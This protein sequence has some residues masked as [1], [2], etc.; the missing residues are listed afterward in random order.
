MLRVSAPWACRILK[1]VVQPGLRHPHPGCCRCAFSQ[2][3]ESTT[4]ALPQRARVVV[5]GGGIAGLSVAYHLSKLGW[6]DIVLLEQGT[7]ASGT[8]WSATGLLGLLRRSHFTTRLSRMSYDLYSQLEDETGIQTGLRRCGSVYIGQT[9]DVMV[10][11]RKKHA[12][13]HA[14]GI[15]SEL[16]SIRDISRVLPWIRVDDAEGGL[17]VKDDARVRSMDV[18]RALAKAIASRGVT[19]LENVVVK[20][21]MTDEGSV[22]SVETDRGTIDCEAFVNCAGLWAYNIGLASSPEVR[23]PVY[24]VAQQYLTTKPIKNLSLDAQ[25]PYIRDTESLLYIQEHNGGFLFGG[26]APKGKPIFDE[27]VPLQKDPGNIQLPDDWDH[28][29]HLLEGFLHRVPLAANVQ[30]EKLSNYPEGF[31]PDGEF[32]MGEAP[33]VRNYYILAGFSSLGLAYAGGAGQL[34]AGLMV[35]GYTSMHYWP[36]DVRRFSPYHNSKEFLRARVKEIESVHYRVLYPATS[37][38]TGRKLRCPPLYS[39]LAQDGAV[40]GERMGVERPK[41]FMAPDDTDELALETQRGMFGKPLWFDLVEAEYW[42]CRES[43]CLMDMSAFTKLELTST[44]NEATMLLQRLCPNDLDCPVGSVVHTG[45][46]N[47]RGGY[48]SDCSIARLDTN[49]YFIICPTVLLVRGHQ[50]IA[51]HLP[52][53]GSVTLRDLTN[54]YAGLN[55]VGPKARE[56]LQKL[57]TTSLSTTDFKPFSCKELNI[58]YATRVKAMTVTH[59]GENG[60]VLYI[61]NESAVQ[62]YDTLRE[63]GKDFG[64]RNAGYYALRWLRI[65]KFYF[66]WGEDFDSTSTPFEIGREMRVK[67]DKGVEFIGRSALL[68]QRQEGVQRRLVGFIM[69]DHN[70]NTDL[71]PWGGEPIYRDGQLAGMTTCSSYGPTQR[72]MTCLGWL[73]NHDP[74]TGRLSEVSPEF[75]HKGRYEIDLAG[76]RFPLKAR[77]YPLQLGAKQPT[78]G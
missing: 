12:N 72:K 57:T 6:K 64:I 76:R 44:G 30:F 34:L 54:Q 10:E 37:Y 55:V 4:P 62:V 19:L 49:R 60:M 69:E 43:V 3:A 42:A 35:D 48:E 74:D 63:A 24:P 51:N 33:E 11:L 13:A 15:D 67:F 38:R 77:L 39:R 9:K 22:S 59:A 78:H 73:T 65:E 53:D 2:D 61:P 26:Y 32:I 23:V 46:L 45:M 31:T 29:R 50:W 68:K 75:V 56:V 40:F 28:F 20:G 14:W 18:T 41:W 70:I 21:I 5:C 1:D 8:T 27:V 47:E 66:Y 7:L 52:A 16:L 58:G 71:W 25:G 17:F 36:V